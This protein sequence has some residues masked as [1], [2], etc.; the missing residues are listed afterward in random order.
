MSKDFVGIQIGAI[1]FVDEGIEKVLDILQNK[2]AVNSLVISALSWSRGNAGRAILGTPDHGG[3]EPDHLIG[4]A[5]WEPSPEYYG[6]S[7]IKAFRAPGP[8]Y[9]GF[10]TL[11]DVIPAARKREMK[12]YPYYCETPRATIRHSNVPNAAQILEVDLFG[13]KAAR[14]CN[15][16]PGYRAWVF[17]FIEDWANLDIDGILWGIE[18]QSGLKAMLSGEVPTC[19]CPHCLAEAERRN[20]DAGRAQAGYRAIYDYLHRIRA[21]EQP[22]DGYFVAFLRILLDYPEVFHW[23]K[24]WLESHRG[25]HRELSGVVKFVDPEK[26]VGFGIWQEINTFS[27]YLRAQFDYDDFREYADWLKPIVYHVPAGA[28]FARYVQTFQPL[29]FHKEGEQDVGYIQ[30]AQAAILRDFTPQQSLDLFYHLLNLDEA[31][32]D[33]LPDRGLSAE[34]VRRETARTV[35]G[36]K[37]EVN[38]YPGIGVG[39]PGGPGSKEIEPEDVKSAIRAAYEGGANGVLLSRNYSETMLKNLEAAGDVLRELGRV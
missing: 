33:E 30:E 1:S 4:G 11:R 29:L 20:I 14:P 22:S 28:R 35:A 2:G 19:F 26:E 32:L 21:G 9:E 34:Y 38:V 27:P 5:F 16:N 15:N 17:S 31:P 36:V 8:L 37:G 23:E 25:L 18:R 3:T 6:N 12:V 39:V 7:P 24:L 13:R 10:D